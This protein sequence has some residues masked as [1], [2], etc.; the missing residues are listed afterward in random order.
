MERKAAEG[1]LARFSHKQDLLDLLEN[2][3]LVAL[4]HKKENV[5]TETVQETIYV[6]D[7]EHPWP[8]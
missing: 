7:V 3:V 6:R 5:I 2:D 4:L 1:T 8:R